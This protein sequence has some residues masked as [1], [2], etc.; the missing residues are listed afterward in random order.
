VN[1]HDDVSDLSTGS[2]SWNRK[3]ETPRNRHS[4][5]AV[6]QFQDFDDMV[7]KIRDHVTVEQQPVNA[8]ADNSNSQQQQQHCSSQGAQSTCTDEDV[9]SGYNTSSRSLSTL[10][11]TYKEQSP[12][13]L[14]P[15]TD[16]SHG[17]FTSREQLRN[18]ITAFNNNSQGFIISLDPNSDVFD[19]FI[20]VQM[21]LIRPVQ[22]VAQPSTIYDALNHNATT[23]DH[24]DS[25]VTT[26]YLP[27]DTVKVIHITS[28][29]STK[30]VIRTLLSKFNIQDNPNKFA[31]Y[32]KFE[33]ST[34]QGSYMRRLPDSQ[35]P[36][37]LCLSWADR[38][39]EDFHKTSFVLQEN[40]T[41]EILWEAFSLPELENFLLI[42]NKEEEEYMK[43][44]RV[45]YRLL[46]VQLHRRLKDLRKDRIGPGAKL[47][48]V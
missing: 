19:G 22:M 10:H 38:D 9:D 29:T 25:K 11:R 37:P 26:F 3:S 6:F 21:N 16:T 27:K 48:P 28:K 35:L 36:L 14:Q 44:I 24:K 15:A 12:I 2:G 39:I 13:S 45:T 32:E 34:Q 47:K 8:I 40:D 4:P 20:R 7:A 33:G 5:V 42:L 17:M 31:L 30:E 23:L 18:R 43:Q 46:K 41:G 1:S